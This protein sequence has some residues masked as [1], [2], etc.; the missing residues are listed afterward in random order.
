MRMF[1]ILDPNYIAHMPDAHKAVAK[2]NGIAIT[3]DTYKQLAMVQQIKEEC[4]PWLQQVDNK[5]FTQFPV[6]RGIGGHRKM[7]IEKQVRLDGRKPKDSTLAL[8][9]FMNNYFKKQFGAPFRNS[10]FVSSEIDQASEYAVDGSVYIVI[11]QGNFKYIWSPE[12][13]DLLDGIH[14]F[15]LADVTELSNA[16]NLE[17]F[18]DNVLGTYKNTDLIG[19]IQAEHEIM[20]RCQSYLGI[21]Y[22]IDL[23]QAHFKMFEELL[24]A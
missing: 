22:T 5:P 7:F 3:P 6:Y 23:T 20:V 19:A 8:H 13:A 15:H 21:N 24:V 16:S 14:E 10:L 12:Y 1:E 9:G 2:N 4:Q 18:E 17:E 11:P